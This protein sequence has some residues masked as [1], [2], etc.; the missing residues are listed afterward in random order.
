M[1]FAPGQFPS[2]QK[3]SFTPVPVKGL[4]TGRSTFYVVSLYTHTRTRARTHT[5]MHTSVHIK[6]NLTVPTMCDVCWHF[7]FF[8]FLDTDH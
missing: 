8:F 2:R 6:K 4:S 3:P 1:T 5:H 7:L